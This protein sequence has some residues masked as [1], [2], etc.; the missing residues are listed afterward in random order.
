MFFFRL[1]EPYF[2]QLKTTVLERLKAFNIVQLFEFLVTKLDAYYKSRIATV[3]NNRVHVHQ[4]SRYHAPK[5]DKLSTLSCT[6]RI[7]E[8]VFEVKNSKSSLTY[9]VDMDAK[10]CSCPKGFTGA[11][12]KHQFYVAKTF[13]ISSPQFH[14]NMWCS[15]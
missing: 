13:N 1:L 9:L 4:K 12:C 6:N 2:L 5:T 15:R 8:R 10:I 7:S 3:L 14:E 11:P